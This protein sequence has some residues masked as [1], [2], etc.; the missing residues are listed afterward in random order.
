MKKY[1]GRMWFLCGLFLVFLW[2][3][4]AQAAGLEVT[5][6][7]SPQGIMRGEVITYTATVKN[8]LPNEPDVVITNKATVLWDGGSAASNEVS[9]TRTTSLRNVLLRCPIPTST[10]FVAGSVVKDGAAAAITPSGTTF[11]VPIGTLAGGAQSV[12]RYQVTAN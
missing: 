8:T 2:A 5:L 9:S 6:Q 12:V 4:P 11:D 1:V 10:T 7:G 3:I